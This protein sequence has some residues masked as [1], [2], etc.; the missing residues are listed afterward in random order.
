MTGWRFTCL[1]WSSWS[2]F[3][4]TCQRPFESAQRKGA[5]A[6]EGQFMHFELPCTMVFH[7]SYPPDDSMEVHKA[8][9]QE[10]GGLPGL[11]A[12]P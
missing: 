12:L 8:P 9:F 11:P 4:F 10:E 7:P 5:P 6:K 1:L 2:Y 3:F